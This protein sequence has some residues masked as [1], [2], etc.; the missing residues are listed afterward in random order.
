MELVVNI[1]RNHGLQLVKKSRTKG[2][3]QY[4]VIFIP[5][6]HCDFVLPLDFDFDVGINTND[7]FVVAQAASV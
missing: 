6:I 2:L 4:F 1:L 7:F 3:L 5:C